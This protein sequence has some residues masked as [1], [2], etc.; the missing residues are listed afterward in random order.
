M[1]A[2]QIADLVQGIAM[3]ALGAWVVLLNPRNRLHRAFGLLMLAF[4]GSALGHAFVSAATF[5]A[6]VA[7]NLAGALAVPFATLFFA[8]VYHG[9]HSRKRNRSPLWRTVPWLLLA[10]LLATE[11]AFALQP[12]LFNGPIL[13]TVLLLPPASGALLVLVVATSFRVAA[14]GPARRAVFLLMLAF[15]LKA[16]FLA[17][18]YLVVASGSGDWLVALGALACLGALLLATGLVAW[19]GP[20]GRRSAGLLL[21]AQGAASL[22]VLTANWADAIPGPPHWSSALITAFAGLWQL[23]GV[24]IVAYAIA[25]YSLF[26]LD[27][28]FRTVLR[29][30]GF[31]VGIAAVFFVVE[32]GLQQLL[33]S[34]VAATSWLGYVE[35]LGIALAV[36]LLLKPVHRLCDRVAGRLVH[37][38]DEGETH[39]LAIYQAA[40]AAAMLDRTVSPGERRALDR[41]ARDLGLSAPDV[42]AIEGADIPTH[43]EASAA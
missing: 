14:P 40:F 26:S 22:S 23:L 30:S 34:Q 9:V 20:E 25:Q 37:G 43:G 42:Q 10:G 29:E 24:G 21:L 3:L 4:A 16:S 8:H 1:Q 31:A 41:L 12:D 36:A 18:L 5:D 17:M 19:S 13:S 38:H 7:V 2:P 27:P 33:S 32:Q 6:A 35:V 39:R 15:S 11:T 28:R